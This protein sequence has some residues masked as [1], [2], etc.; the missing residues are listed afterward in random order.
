MKQNV[1]WSKGIVGVTSIVFLLT[2]VFIVL[3]YVYKGEDNLFS[4]CSVMSVVIL[5]LCIAIAYVYAPIALYLEKDMLVLRRGVGFKRIL[6]SD[7]VEAGN[8]TPGNDIRY[9]GI[10]GLFGYIGYF[11]RR[12]FGRYFAY[13]GDYSQAFYV[14]LGNGR[15]Y[16]FSCENHQAFLQ[17]LQQA[18]AEV[19]G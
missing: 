5:V 14:V 7:I 1:H 12:D 18:V 9:C 2:A 8:Y 4:A 13:V 6:L 15:R 3:A 11:G 19:R 17:A 10:G 16:V